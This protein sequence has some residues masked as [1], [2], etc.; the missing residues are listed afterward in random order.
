MALKYRTVKLPESGWIG[1]G[2]CD[3][4][5]LVNGV[6]CPWRPRILPPRAHALSRL[7]TLHEA[8][9]HLA[10]TTP[11]ILAKPEVARAIEQALVEAM[12][13][14]L[15]DTRSDHVR[16]VERHRT[17]VMRR[18]ERALTASAEEPLYM[19]GLSAQVGTSYW[20]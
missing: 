1:S 20:K 4:R 7:R 18:L 9:G 17:R 3:R 5:R 2:T 10:K 12:V 11:D 14:C 6:R 16:N 8:A 13:F 15:A 19:A